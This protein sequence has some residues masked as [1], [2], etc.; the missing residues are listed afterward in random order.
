MTRQVP[1]QINVGSALRW[2]GMLYRN[3][4]DAVKE[5]ISNA[6]DEHLKAQRAGD[7]VTYCDVVFSLDRR[8]ITIEYPY[9][10]DRREFEAAL[11]RVAD[12]AKKASDVSQIGRLGIGIFSF[13][14]IGRKCTFLSKKNAE[15]DTIRVTLTEGSDRAEF[16]SAQK[17]EALE[18]PGIR[19]QITDLKFDPTKPRGPLSPERLQQTFAEKFNGYLRKGWLRIKIR[20]E[21]RVYD[22]APLPFDL[23]RLAEGL[24][25]L[26]LPGQSRKIVGLN[27][28]FD[29][30]G[31]GVVSISHMGVAVVEDIKT[32]SAYGLEESIYA[33]GYV[34]GFIDADFLEPLPARTGF[35]ENAD[36]IAFLNLLDRQRPQIEAEVEILRQEQREKALSEIQRAA[37][38]M[39]RE[40]LDSEEFRDLELPGGTTRAKSPPE[41]ERK[42]P[43]GRRTGERSTEPGD[44]RQPGGLRINYAVRPFETGPARHSRLVGGEVQA[45]ELNPDFKRETTGPDEAKLAYATLI[46]G[47]EVVAYNDKAGAVDDYLERLLTFY[48]RVKERIAPHV[49]VPGKRGRGRPRKLV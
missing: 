29:P 30:S 7:A 2:L 26:R 19:I 10:M 45:N 12:S 13:Q 28:Y 41:K 36:W 37:I 22:V 23:P 35:E 49:A 32:L 16:D 3:P 44:R 48:F 8:A 46:I 47:K 25:T 20:S 31:R 39:A 40:I 42:V 17:R 34:K 21:S 14:Q 1:I 15:A 11:Q 5:H 6:I 4:A 38:L 9:G 43:T 33:S 18:K 24:E 27:L